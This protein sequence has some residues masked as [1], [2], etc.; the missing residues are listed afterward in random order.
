MEE[1]TKDQAIVG[2]EKAEKTLGIKREVLIE[3][4]KQALEQHHRTRPIY[5]PLKPEDQT[6][7]NHRGITISADQGNNPIERT[8]VIGVNF[9]T[10]GERVVE[11]RQEYTIPDAFLIMRGESTW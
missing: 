3:L 6:T 4:I 9:K 2:S 11:F 5:T 1:Y 7:G 10:E 8:V